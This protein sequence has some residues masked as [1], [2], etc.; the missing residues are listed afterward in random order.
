[1][2]DMARSKYG[3]HEMLVYEAGLA[4]TNL[5]S[6]SSLRDVLVSG[7]EVTVCQT[8][9]GGSEKHITYKEDGIRIALDLVFEQNA[10]VQKAGL[11]LMCNLSNSNHVVARWSEKCRI[12]K[13]QGLGPDKSADQ[14]TL[15]VEIK[16]LLLFCAPV[17]RDEREILETEREEKRRVLEENDLRLKEARRAKRKEDEFRQKLALAKREKA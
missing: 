5:A 8:N 10:L 14:S 2:F 12:L 9:L 13:E 17:T 15:P 1:M 7:R 11:E 6:S 16:V 4:L 3:K